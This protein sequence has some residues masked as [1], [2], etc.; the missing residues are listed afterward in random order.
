MT[1]ST[2]TL[3]LPRYLPVVYPTQNGKAEVPVSGAAARR[4]PGRAAVG[5]SR[6]ELRDDGADLSVLLSQV[7]LRFTIDFEGES[8]ISL[9]ISANTLRVLG[10]CGPGVRRAGTCRR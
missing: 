10:R 4:W 8:R 1:S 5:P 3:A 7:L 9:P 2:P 6:A